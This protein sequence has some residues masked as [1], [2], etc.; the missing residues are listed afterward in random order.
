MSGDPK[1]SHIAR[2]DLGFMVFLDMYALK[3]FL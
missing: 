2:W 3:T 1:Q